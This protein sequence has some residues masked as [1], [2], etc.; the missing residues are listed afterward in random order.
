MERPT[1]QAGRL[2][3]TYAST[4]TSANDGPTWLSGRRDDGRAS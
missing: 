4:D 2:T 3:A 1:V